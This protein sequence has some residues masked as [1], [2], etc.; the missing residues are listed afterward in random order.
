MTESAKTAL[1]ELRSCIYQALEGETSVRMDIYVK[2]ENR[3]MPFKFRIGSGSV[4]MNIYVDETGCRCE[5]QRGLLGTVWQFA[6]RGLK[7]VLDIALP[8]VFDYVSTKAIEWL[9]K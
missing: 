6:K 2:G 9:K 5:L 4:H 1:R 7:S 3:G 8:I